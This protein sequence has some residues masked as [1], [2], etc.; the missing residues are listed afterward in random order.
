MKP[1]LGPESRESPDARL[2]RDRPL[3]DDGGATPLRSWL[4][5]K[6]FVNKIF[7]KNRDR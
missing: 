4:K 1:L 6:I 5:N 7:V 3:R 2:Q